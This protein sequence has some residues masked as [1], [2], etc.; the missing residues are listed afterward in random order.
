MHRHR[1]DY[2]VLS[3]M[4][5]TNL[6]DTAFVLLIAFIIVSPTMRPGMQLALP[7]VQDLPNLDL[8]NK[9]ISVVI[10]AKPSPDAAEPIYLVTEGHDERVTLA[11]LGKGIEAK[12]EALKGKIDVVVEAEKQTSYDTFAQVIGVLK[13]LGIEGIGLATDPIKPDEQP[14][15]DKDKDKNQKTTATP[16]PTPEQH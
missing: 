8:P 11:D 6:L 2:E 7:Q 5:L 16:V 9:T 15:K 10:K 12:R 13:N 14:A 3:E 4:N 1:R